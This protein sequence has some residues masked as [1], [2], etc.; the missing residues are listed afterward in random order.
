MQKSALPILH[1]I[2]AFDRLLLFLKQGL[3]NF[4]IRN[5]FIQ[6]LMFIYKDHLQRSWRDPE[7]S[8]GRGFEDSSDKEERY[9]LKGP[10]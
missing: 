4:L 7:D 5:I 10:F 3:T 6:E 8:R 1:S 2:I 9:G